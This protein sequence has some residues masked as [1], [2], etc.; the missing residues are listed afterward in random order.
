M[1][2]LHELTFLL[3]TNIPLMLYIDVKTYSHTTSIIIFNVL[4]RYFNVYIL[5]IVIFIFRDVYGENMN[6][7][8]SIAKNNSLLYNFVS[9]K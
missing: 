9:R 4:I 8:L 3:Y 5:I 7:I 2:Y 1:Q 6:S